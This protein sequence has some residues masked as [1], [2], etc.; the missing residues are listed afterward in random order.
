MEFSGSHRMPEGPSLPAE[1]SLPSGE[2]KKKSEKD[3]TSGKAE[4]SEV[5]ASPNREKVRQIGT[6]GV[7][8]EA[9][10]W[11]RKQP[12]GRPAETTIFQQER[13]GRQEHEGDEA[14][15]G[16]SE[17]AETTIGPLE[18]LDI[19]V[20]Y[21]QNRT[22]ELEA[23][24][25]SSGAAESHRTET[26]AEGTSAEDAIDLEF[27][28]TLSEHL[29]RISEKTAQG[30]GK[31]SSVEEAADA[32]FDEVVGRRGLSEQAASMSEANV[33]E[34]TD[35]DEDQLTATSANAA[36]AAGAPP[37]AGGVAGGPPPTGYAAPATAMGGNIGRSANAYA[38]PVEAAPARATR[39]AADGFVP[40]AIGATLGYFIGKRRGGRNAEQRLTPQVQKL[41]AEVKQQITVITTKEAKIR[42]LVRMQ[43]ESLRT[44]AKSAPLIE[45]A[46][47]AEAPQDVPRI[48]DAPAAATRLAE[49]SP[50]ARAEQT[51]VFSSTPRSERAPQ[52]VPGKQET[53]PVLAVPAE[54][55]SKQ[56]LLEAG[57]AITIGSESLRSMYEGQDNKHLIGEEGLR[58]L[59]AE[60]QRGHDI[61]P[62]LK[63]EMLKYQLHF[64]RLDDTS[65]QSADEARSA[66][67]EA[68]QGGLGGVIGMDTA[69][70]QAT[71]QTVAEAQSAAAGHLQPQGKV[72]TQ[73]HQTL[74]PV[75][76]VANV[77]AFIILAILVIVLLTI[78]L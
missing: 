35:E 67:Q 43:N 53:R 12:E 22:A 21:A 66:V 27:M 7:G 69:S 56:E 62:V 11:R 48:P 77:I 70:P 16:D 55:M 20:A 13:P 40:F 4:K 73:S 58:R 1:G 65:Q 64:E 28:N 14:S 45:V 18:S 25:V 44:P 26:I 29:V 34:D 51:P 78:Y 37:L 36:A 33:A 54:T 46:R 10:S 39:E 24:V 17:T 41:E 8:D 15:E 71:A 75:L 52:A 50:F 72:Q 3:K 63:E 9:P 57:A 61:G 2:K 76:V 31:V 49:A 32:A 30:E 60:Y 6:L 5:G 38:A 47:A 19:A 74:R 59:V 68:H 42:Q 23:N